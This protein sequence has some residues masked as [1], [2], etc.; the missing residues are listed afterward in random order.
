MAD[1]G[2][3]KLELLTRPDDRRGTFVRRFI[4]AVGWQI[5]LRDWLEGT[6]SEAS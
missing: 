2:Q 3:T 5:R 4:H 1:A 6:F